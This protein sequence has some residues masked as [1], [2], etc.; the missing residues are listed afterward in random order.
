MIYLNMALDTF[1]TSVVNPLNYICF[2]SFVIV[3]SS[4]LFEEWRNILFIDILATLVGL[5]VVVIGLFMMNVLK[6][7]QIPWSELNVTAKKNKGNIYGPIQQ[8]C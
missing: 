2:T 1:D 3:A 5:G 7:V 6:T 4:I 8:S